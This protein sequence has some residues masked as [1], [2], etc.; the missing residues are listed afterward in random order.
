MD[1]SIA[2]H[3]GVSCLLACVSIAKHLEIFGVCQA[4]VSKRQIA[5]AAAVD[6]VAEH[7][8]LNVYESVAV[9]R[10]VGTATVDSVPDV[11]DVI[12]VLIKGYCG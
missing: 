1:L 4:V 7:S 9:N 5:V 12:I 8:A 11:R 10:T 6:I 2:E 3:V